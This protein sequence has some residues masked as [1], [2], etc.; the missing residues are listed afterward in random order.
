MERLK[1][2]LTQTGVN[3]TDSIFNTE[4]SIE[5]LGSQPFVSSYMHHRLSLV[6]VT[7]TYTLHPISELTVHAVSPSHPH[8]L[9]P[10]HP[11]KHIL[12]GIHDYCRILKQG[13]S[14]LPLFSLMPVDSCVRYGR[15]YYN[16]THVAIC[17]I[18]LYA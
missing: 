18:E 7:L 14:S 17:T 6:V 4:D 16:N 12:F 15:I 3:F 5:G 10:S 2:L 13:F 9:T 1:G 11:H 8:T